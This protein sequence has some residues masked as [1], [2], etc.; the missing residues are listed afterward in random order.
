MKLKE[1]TKKA[2]TC[3]LIAALFFILGF[4]SHQFINQEQAASTSTDQSE[5]Y[6][7]SDIADWEELKRMLDAEEQ[8]QEHL[9]R[10]REKN[11]H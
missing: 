11:S 4:V 6:T 9:D 5:S 1:P 10:I 2:L 7:S 8:W 3:S